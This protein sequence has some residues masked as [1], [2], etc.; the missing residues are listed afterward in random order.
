MNKSI[1]K[2]LNLDFN[3]PKSDLHN[4]LHQN[5][6]YI[7]NAARSCIKHIVVRGAVALS[8][9][10]A[11]V[12]LM[13][14]SNRS[15]LAQND[16]CAT[17]G[18]D[19]VVNVSEVVNTYFIGGAPGEI[20][21]PGQKSLMLP[22]SNP[23]GANTKI[24]PGD[25]LMIIQMQDATIDSDNDATYGSG[26]A[27]NDGSG[28]VS[29]GNSGRYEF[30]RATNTVELT[31]GL[32]EF[33]AGGV[34]G[35]LQNQYVN[36][37]ATDD[38]GQRTFQVIRVPQFATLTLQ[39]DLIVPDW[40]GT[41]GGILAIDV[42][43]TID[44]NGFTIDGTARG[45]RGGYALSGNSGI[46]IA[47]YVVPASDTPTTNLAGGKGEGIAGT[48]RFTWDGTNANDLGSDRLPGGDA[49]R[50]APA[51]A[52]GG[53][54]DHNSGGGGGGNGGKGGTGGIGWE[55]IGFRSPANNTDNTPGG[56][57]GA[58]P[59]VPSISRLIMGGGGG[60]GDAN[61]ET[62]GVRGGQGG[63][64]VMIRAGEFIGSG[65]IRVNGSDGEQGEFNNAPD[66]A[67]GGGAG[68]TVALIAEN[69]GLTGVTV[70][71]VGGDGGDTV[72]DRNNEHG[73]GG[74]GA[75]GVIVSYS[76][77]GQVGS[78]IVDGGDGGR[79]D[80]GNGIPHGTN[81]GDGGIATLA[82][83]GDIPPILPG[84]QCIPALTVS[85]TEA[86]PGVTGERLAPNTAS[87]TITASNTGNGS[88]AGVR[89]KDILPAGFTYN[90]GATATLTGGATGSATPSNIG[91]AT[92]PEFGDYLIPSGGEVIIE[93]EVNIAANTP[94]GV[95]QNPAYISYL[96]PSRI[97][98][99]RRITPEVGAN[100]GDNT[101]YEAGVNAGQTVPGTN[102]IA[103]STVDENVHITSDNPVSSLT[104]KIVINEILFRQTAGGRNGNDEF[105]ELFNTWDSPVDISGWQ[106]I[107]GN[108]LVG[109]TDG[110]GSI[111]GS[112]LPFVFP[113]GTIL[114]PGEYAVIWVGADTGT[115]NKQA[116]IPAARQFYLGQG[117]KLRDRGDDMWLYDAQTRIVDY[118]AYGSNT[119]T[120]N[121]VNTPPD[122]ALNLWSDSAQEDL[123]RRID[124]GQSISLTPNGRD[125]NTS[126]CWEATTSEDAEPR[127]QTYLL[128]RDT[129]RVGSRITSVGVNNN[130]ARLALVKRIT[131]LIPNRQ[132]V[133]FNS[134]IEDG[135]PNNEDNHPKWHSDKNTYLR[136]QVGGL[137]VQPGDEI[138][139]T[140]YFLSNGGVPANEVKL[141]DVIPDHTT[142]V[143]DTY[144]VESGIALGLSNSSLP[145]QPN[146]TLSNLLNDDRGN[147]YA[148]GTQ[149]PGFCQKNNSQPPHE[150][151]SVDGNNNNAGAVVV[152]LNSSL[153]YATDAGFPSNSYG[154]IRF[155]TKVK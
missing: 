119:N 106:L 85:K 125:G 139:Y 137:E 24:T 52:G 146:I 70:E 103:S 25:M 44:F 51:N 71:A 66:G 86:N 94:L 117:P 149:P 46:N 58:I 43:N 114:N 61:N 115:A 126:L 83:P 89:I 104:G 116:P 135:I 151:I 33:E 26:D 12:P 128:T 22:G 16:I 134:F 54:N 21:S 99:G 45:F 75:G 30:V 133:N 67:G 95:Y 102:Y 18:K 88:A 80:N 48:P 131:D 38:Q 142:F 107:D 144:G 1:I 36:S 105:I 55:G 9:V 77:G 6:S 130:G 47:D 62:N 136:G 127:C 118:V 154:F 97:T 15:V 98:P 39:S 28:A 78:A 148:P 19:G 64:I 150:L 140:I 17:P 35:G 79:A 76:P 93:F 5:N 122:S 4:C 112:N 123:R 8:L 63:G 92:S 129:D 74:A 145:I 53:G 56:R 138:E 147:F 101:T 10:C 82:V 7:F 111:T 91:N 59:A 121:A 69:G 96:D 155:R 110:G 72:N 3:A 109:S 34:G 11:Q 23:N 32:L 31:G 132:G 2:Y 27:A 73:P 141:C 152:E 100:S 81:S 143:R 153:P 90:G 60:G 41:S 65:T 20:A 57:G 120:N 14:I 42:A 13:L 40:D 49:G 37:A 68:G 29:I 50:G 84:S 108:L 124:P 87:Y 113:A